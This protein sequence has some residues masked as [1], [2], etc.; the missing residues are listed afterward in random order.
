MVMEYGLLRRSIVPHWYGVF[1]HHFKLGPSME[2]LGFPPVAGLFMRDGGYIGCPREV[3]A[4]F[5]INIIYLACITL[6]VQL[7]I[8]F[9]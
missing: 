7:M 9:P 3:V 5:K 8:P 6:Q 4:I 1:Y 2:K